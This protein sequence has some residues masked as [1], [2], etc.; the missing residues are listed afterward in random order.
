MDSETDLECVAAAVIIHIYACVTCVGTVKK[1][2]KRSYTS[3]R[4]DRLRLDG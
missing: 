3:K 2:K 4:Y 1:K